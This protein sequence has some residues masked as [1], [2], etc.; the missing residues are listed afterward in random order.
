MK[1]AKC[2]N[3]G[4]SIQVDENSDSGICPYCN[5]AYTTEKAIALYSNNTTNNA[6]VI[7]NFYNQQPSTTHVE[8]VEPRPKINW[9]LAIVGLYFGLI[10][11]IIYIGCKIGQQKNWDAKYKS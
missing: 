5:T 11:G 8:V 3:C 7:N 10:P 2:T 9:F 6:S 1:N 4:A